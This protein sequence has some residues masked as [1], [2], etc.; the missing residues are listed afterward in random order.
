M[1]SKSYV[2]EELAKRVYNLVWVCLPSWA[3][4]YGYGPIGKRET[5]FGVTAK[6]QLT[7]RTATARTT[8]NIVLH[9]YDH[10]ELE[11]VADALA[12]EIEAKLKK[13]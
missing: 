3:V 4:P 11:H 8:V 9:A 6:H 1:M 7:E 10:G 13:A 12:R 2:D 5:V